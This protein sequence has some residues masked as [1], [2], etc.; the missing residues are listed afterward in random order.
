MELRF[1]KVFGE[2][3]IETNDKR[4]S[5]IK[6]YRF[7]TEVFRSAILEKRDGFGRFETGN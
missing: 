2:M 3:N 6:V 4:T 1:D 5:V 7:M